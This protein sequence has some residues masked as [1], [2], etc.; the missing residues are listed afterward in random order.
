MLAQAGARRDAATGAISMPVHPSASFQHPALGRSTG[1][2]YSRTA[3]P[4]RQALEEVMAA[5][6]GGARAS[7]FSSGLA[8][9]DAVLR[10]FSPGDALVVTE[11]VY[12]GTSRLFEVFGRLQGLNFIAVDSSNPRAVEE[13]VAKA[14]ERHGKVR[15]F[16]VEF[17]TNPLLKV[18]DIPALAALARREGALLVVDNT[19]LT[20]AFCRP[21][22]LGADLALYS[23]TKYLGGHNDLVAGL[24]VARD[25]DLGAQ[26]A[27]VQNAVG[28]ILGPFESWLLLRSLKT[29]HLRLR[30]QE[31]NAQRVAAFLTTQPRVSRVFYPG[32]ASSPGHALLRAQSSGFGSVL[33]FEVESRALLEHILA[34]VRIF[35]FAE[36][37][38]GTESLVTFPLEQTHVDVPPPVLARL[39]INDR[40]LR[41]SVGIE[42]AEDL[43]EDLRAVLA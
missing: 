1:Y 22:E 38:G 19:F 17:P 3:N 35:M 20:P 28:A 14:R 6:E 24:V 21:L 2:D 18:A 41:L 29:L 9:V 8:A 33:S 39:G 34:A 4:T 27:F 5:F 31:E 15:G 43:L 26:V 32:L 16:I 23:A 37:L 11:D 30:R 36:S 12:G 40:L 13:G 42:D 10:Q 25:A 7:A